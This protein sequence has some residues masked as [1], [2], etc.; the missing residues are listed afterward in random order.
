MFVSKLNATGTALVYSTYLGG[1]GDDEGMGI[2]VDSSGRAYV[3]G[4]TKSNNFPTLNAFQAA[5]GGG[6]DAFLTV[7]NAA[8]NGLVYST[9]FGGTGASD[10]GAGIAI[11]PAGDVVITGSTNSSGLA[12][13]GAYQTSLTGTDAYV[14]VFNTSQSGSSSLLD[15]TYFGSGNE[16]ANGVAIDAAGHIYITGD[17]KSNNLP[18][19]AG[20]YQSTLGG[21]TD[22]YV[23][24]FNGTLSSLL[25][26]SYFGGTGNEDGLAIAV[27]SSNGRIYFGGDTNQ[28]IPIT[29]NA[30]DS[31]R[32]GTDGYFTIID[33]AQSGAAG[34]IYSTYIGGNMNMDAV[35]AIALDGSGRAYL[36]GKTDAMSG[37]QVTSNAYQSTGGGGPDAFL[38]VLDPSQ[39]GS[40]GLIYGTYLGGPAPDM[41]YGIAYSSGSAYIVGQTG[42]NS[43]IATSGA[44][45]TAFGGGQDGFVARF[46]INAPPTV[47]TPAAAAPSPV[48]GTSTALSVLGADAGG[49]ASLTYTWMVTAKPAGAGNP[50]Y[51]ANGTNAAKNTT[52]TFSQAG[53]YTFLVTIA[54]TGGLTATSSIGVTV[55]QTLTTITDSPSSASLN[56]NGTQSFSAIGYDQFGAALAVQPSFTWAEASGVGSINASGLYTAGS[57]AGSATITA[58]SGSVAGS[59]AVTVTNA[60]PT[61]ATPAAA[62]PNPVTGSLHGPER[63]RQRRWRRAQPDLHLDRHRR[64]RRCGQPHLQRQRHE[65]SQEHHRHILTGRQ[66]HLPGDDRRHRWSDR[67]Q[68]HRRHRQPD[69]DVDHRFTLVGESEPQRHPVVLRDR[70]RPVR[71]RARRATELHL[72]RGQRGRLDQCLRPLHRGECRRL[73]HDHGDQRVGRRQC[74]GHGDQRRAD[75]R[76]ARRGGANPVT[77][78]STALSVLGSDDGGEPNLTYTWTVTAEPAGA[79]NPTF[80]A[81]GTNAAKNTTATF[82]QA[83]SYT[84]LVTIADTG[85]LTATSSIGVTV[86]QTL[87][88]ITDSPSSASLNLNGTQSF[89]AIGYDQFGA[90]LAVQPSFTWAE[91]SGVGS[92]NASGLYTAG[93][94]AGSAT[95]TATSGSVAGSA[96][97]TVTNAAPTVATPAAAAPNPVT[98]TST[99]LSVLG[100]DDGGESNLTYTWT[101]TAE[102]AGAANPTYSANGTNAAKNTTATFSQAGS[103]TFLV[104]IADT[105]GLTATSSIG[106]TVDQT[107]T[108]ITDS[109]SS[110]SLNLNG[111]QSFSAIG[112]DQFGAALAVQ[113]SFTWAEASGVGSINA[114]GLYTAGSVAGSATI[115]ATSGVGRRQGQ[116]SR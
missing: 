26:A 95:I 20:A 12:T 62:A 112:Y 4:N 91:A 29:A 51:S 42:S 45:Q 38:V 64:A 3:V 11:N 74:G 98:G 48:T 53:N 71:C 69:A 89:S 96:A 7:L 41:A 104:T 31:T 86:N 90:A 88:T 81:N 67:H 111:T 33:P 35:N 75:G 66:L 102:P 70:L 106:V 23:A 114:S 82:S 15:S 109:P 97:V 65:R 99:A 63:A 73:G 57:V 79:A 85:G 108:S 37:F 1:S 77:G 56:L 2:A 93:S 17:T 27:N 34:L 87:T 60:A 16:T 44:Y 61:V 9:Y 101:V 59:A 76:H 103:Y 8:G 39:S 84:F 36:A 78:S 10:T 80:S 14:A 21:G 107:L 113:P 92:I 52:A 72:G 32:A 30:V 6:E 94:V 47:A 54:D 43:G 105:G 50:T 25:Y 115:T 46:V 110:A 58:T 83:G 40:A 22:A 13:A 68:Q 49:E 5:N 100:S 55:N 28:N 116:Q 24:E 18:V 19:T